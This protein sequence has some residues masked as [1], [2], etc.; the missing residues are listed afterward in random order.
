[1]S[2]WINVKH[3]LPQEGTEVAVWIPSWG[4]P[5]I[6][7]INWDY[8]GGWTIDE[9][10]PLEAQHLPTHWMPLPKPPAG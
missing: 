1:M 4:R 6:G 3:S 2:E 5:Y 7:Y 8:D 9:G 10:T